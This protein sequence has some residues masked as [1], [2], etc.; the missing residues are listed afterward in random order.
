MF[1][2]NFGLKKIFQTSALSSFFVSTLIPQANAAIVSSQ[3]IY[4][5]A[6][7]NEIG[8]L[9]KI[10]NL[11][12]TDNS[13]NTAL[14]QAILKND[15]ASY[16]VLE[17][18]GADTNAPCVNKIPE[19]RYQ[20]F[21]NDLASDGFLGLSSSTWLW[22]SL[23]VT[24]ALAALS[25]GGGGGGGGD[26]SSAAPVKKPYNN[27]VITKTNTSPTTFYGIYYDDGD[28]FDFI[29]NAND[30]TAKIDLTQKSSSSVYGI[31]ADKITGVSNARASSEDT[32][33]TIIIDNQNSGNAYGIYATPSKRYRYPS[34]TNASN[35]RDTKGLGEILIR[36]ASSGTA[37]GIYSTHDDVSIYNAH[38]LDST[39]TAKGRIYIKNEKYG[40]AYGIYSQ[41]GNIYTA[42]GTNAISDIEIDNEGNGKAYGIYAPNG[43]VESS[44]N[45]TVSVNNSGGGTAFGIVT[46]RMGLSSRY[47]SKDN[48]L[49]GNF[50][51]GNVVGIKSN[52]NPNLITIFSSSNGTSTGFI[53]SEN[54]GSNYGTI[55]I[56]Q[57]GRGRAIG[58][59]TGKNSA[60]AENAKIIIHNT[61][62]GTAVG[63]IAQAD[64]G[65]NSNCVYNNGNILINNL[66]NGTAIGM[67][68]KKNAHVMN[69]GSIT[70]V[71]RAFS[72][73]DTTYT[74]T[75]ASG[76]TAYGIYAETGATVSNRGTISLEGCIT[77]QQIKLNGAALINYGTLSA[78]SLNLEETGGRITASKG[79]KFKVTGEM[80]GNLNVSSD[81]VTNGFDTVYTA[82]NVIEAGDTSKL[83]T[84]SES[85]LFKA[86]LADNKKDIVLRMK[87]F[88]SATENSSLA[89]F[90][91]KNYANAKNENFFNT[92]KAATSSANLKATLN[93]MTG[94]D[95]LKQFISDDLSNFRANKFTLND[96]LFSHHSNENTWAFAGETAL[97]GFKNDN[98]SN[99]RLALINNRLSSKISLGY[100]M[101]YSAISTNDDKGNDRAS[102]AMQFYMPL[103]YSNNDARL[104]STAS[105]G[106]AKNNYTR[107]GFNTSYNGEIESRVFA[108]ANEGRYRIETKG[109]S[110]EPTTEFNAVVYN[111]SGKEDKKEFSL[112]IPNSTFLSLESGIGL[113]LSKNIQ[114][115]KDESISFKA[116]VMAYHEFAN[117]Y[118][119]KLG[120]NGMQGTFDLY[121]DISRDRSE[122]SFGLT[123]K[124]KNMRINADMRHFA[125]RD[126][127]SQ[128][129][130][131]ASLDF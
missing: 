70:I 25:S 79:S 51:T 24:G 29:G 108:L 77:C 98:A 114:T 30:G 57:N 102:N 47:D 44:G 31:Y 101:S 123:Y 5:L 86:S 100:G 42:D 130:I 121:D 71:R 38:A 129:K 6:K 13:G 97:F 14:C 45:S 82:H 23:G 84:V 4:E 112:T 90:L 63:M 105:I 28:E 115:N 1:C 128:I 96:E 34:I 22:G 124:R 87:S 55:T 83:N 49:M 73:G 3:K 67:Y 109:L 110:I 103:T 76:G 88:D 111:Q 94:G 56:F 74:P 16:R 93:S 39:A 58:M 131:S 120:M 48:V 89:R 7:N 117:P 106:Y 40:T 95:S 41:N 37:Y 113:H 53:G 65:E 10:K 80:S 69:L 85:A 104:I 36:N 92:L 116:G 52:L 15:T 60:N 64:A 11:N 72:I 61:G 9:L 126:S 21:M 62:N 91:T 81:Y 18:A 20:T 68:A 43:Y 12:K 107:S 2:S 50:G 118:N 125:Q 66:A 99:S 46:K 33:G 59:I 54:F 26:S 122:I 32:V 17:Q 78:T 27:A 35:F 19:E 127:H 8:E 119:V 75:S